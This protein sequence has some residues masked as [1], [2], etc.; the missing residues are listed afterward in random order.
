M[1]DIFRSAFS[2]LSQAAPIRAGSSGSGQSVA[3]GTTDHPL[4]GTTVDIAGNKYKYRSLL[5]EGGYALVFAVQ[6][7]QGNW[8]ALKRQLAA[9][10]QAADAIIQEINF[11]KEL[12]G[13]P[14][15]ITFVQAS[16]L[17]PK[18]TSHGRAEFLMLTELCA[19]GPLINILQ[20]HVLSPEQICKIFHSTSS[21]VCHMH[22]RNPPITHRD[23]KMAQYT[24]PMYRAPEILDTYQNFPIGPAQ[25]VW[26][27]GCILYYLCYRQHPFE[28]SA[29]LRIIN[30]KFTLPEGNILHPNPYSRP[31]IQDLC[32]RID[33]LAF[34]L[35]VDLT[36]PVSGLEFSSLPVPTTPATAAGAEPSSARSTPPIGSQPNSGRASEVTQASEMFAQLKGQGMSLFK[37]LKDKSAAVSTYG[38]KGPDITW[39][40]GKLAMSILAEGI[41][42]ALAYSAE[43]TM[44]TALFENNKRNFAVFN[45]AQ[46]KLRLDYNR[47]LSEMS[48]MPTSSG[49]PPAIHFII[50]LC[51]NM[52]TFLGKD[53]DGFIVITGSETQCV[54]VSAALLIFL[55]IAQSA[56]QALEFVWRQRESQIGAARTLLPPSYM[57]QLDL[58][59]TIMIH[60]RPVY[61]ESIYMEPL[62]IVNRMRTGCR[63]FFE[64]YSAGNKRWSTMKEYDQLRSYEVT[65]DSSGISVNLG[66]VPVS[67]DVVICC[68]HARWNRIQNRVQQ[69]LIF[70]CG[71]HT[72]F[73]DPNADHLTFDLAELDGNTTDGGEVAV[74]QNFR[75]F[76]IF[77]C[78]L[79]LI[80]RVL[81]GIRTS[82]VDRGFNPGEDLPIYL[83]NEH[84]VAPPKSIAA[85]QEEYD[86]VCSQL[87]CCTES[88]QPQSAVQGNPRSAPPPRPPAPKHGNP[89]Q[90]FSNAR[91]THDTV[92]L[93]N[94]FGERKTKGAEKEAPSSNTD[95]F[96]NLDWNTAEITN[97]KPPSPPTRPQ[98]SPLMRQQSPV[99]ES[100]KKNEPKMDEA[101][102]CERIF[103]C[104]KKDKNPKSNDKIDD[105]VNEV[106]DL[107]GLGDEARPASQKDATAN[108]F[109]PFSPTTNGSNG[110]FPTTLLGASNTGMHR[111]VS[112][113]AFNQQQKKSGKTDFDDQ[114]EQFLASSSMSNSASKLSSAQQTGTK[115]KVTENAFDDLLSSTGFSSTAKNSNR[116]L[117]D[118]R[119]EEEIKEMD[120]VRDWTKGK[121]RNIRALLG[122]LH[123]IIWEDVSERWT[124]PSMADLLSHTQI[125]KQYFKACLV[126]HPDKLRDNPNE[127]LARAIFSEL[128]DAWNAFEA[129]KDTQ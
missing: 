81:V 32:E 94:P 78:W 105:L 45:L 82:S 65:T 58:L 92:D 66:E 23:I 116:T 118:L 123:E 14:S 2:Y 43:D 99:P 13:H 71:F 55:R 129:A 50:I 93:L 70:S 1:S 4:V 124:Q 104:D 8:F 128:R 19:G 16:Q 62:P 127:A 79:N 103:D 61:L 26:A 68:Y 46:R 12:N 3:G 120:P 34:T 119:R 39:V 125:K 5:A 51:R 117:A 113:P 80:F 48:M 18:Q 60:N 24:T 108:F 7:A 109:D 87:S 126:V 64:V 36:Q 20:K 86:R 72:H 47:R 49:I 10:K 112:A 17:A 76:N 40:S 22:D 31:S 56:K 96:A 33:A 52:S 95:F 77:G 28:D 63:P 69:V 29:K 111:N 90:S 21:A 107:L 75:F 121:E 101:E 85:S 44:R 102:L 38:S 110:N 6:D 98:Q 42:E 91:Q 106:E 37:N 27:L 115:T 74:A 67:D 11:L 122:S 97:V 25:D 15:I 54:L 57:R 89:E 84:Q 73:L 100:N 9:D 30:A 59:H 35:K 114:F 41:P 53:R 83:T 88:A